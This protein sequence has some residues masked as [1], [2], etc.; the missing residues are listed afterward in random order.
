IS[1]TIAS[2]ERNV[3]PANNQGNDNF[4]PISEEI[5]AS[6][7]FGG[8]LCS[9]NQT[10]NHNGG[11]TPTYRGGHNQ[12]TTRIRTPDH[13]FKDESDGDDRNQGNASNLEELVQML[14]SQ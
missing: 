14:T 7:S 6:F 11:V 2:N 10:R 4:L 1:P 5:D 3:L 12:R 8:D 9:G 13:L